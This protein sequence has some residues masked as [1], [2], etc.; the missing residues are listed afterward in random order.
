M[1]NGFLTEANDTQLPMEEISDNPIESASAY[2]DADKPQ[3]EA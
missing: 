2:R 3:Q 1:M